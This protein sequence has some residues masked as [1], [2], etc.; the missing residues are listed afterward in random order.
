MI[1]TIREILQIP[2]LEGCSVLVDRAGIGLSVYQLLLEGLRKQV[3]C[4]VVPVRI[5]NGGPGIGTG[6][7][8]AV[9]Q[10]IIS[11]LQVLLQTQRLLIPR[12][13]PEAK[14]LIQE[15]ENY[16]I[17]RTAPINKDPLIAWREGQ[18]DD[19]VFAVALVS[20]AAEECLPVLLK[21]QG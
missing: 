18:D 9:K 1:S 11:T 13:L 8:L 16:T 3:R 5:T 19:L 4:R 17:H 10:E 12:S 15:L 2:E 7:Y 6:E 21:R 20:W 14:M